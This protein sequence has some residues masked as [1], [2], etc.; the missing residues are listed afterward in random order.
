[1]KTNTIEKM[2]EMIAKAFKAFGHEGCLYRVQEA[3]KNGDYISAAKAI[4]NLKGSSDA[5]RQRIYA[6]CGGRSSPFAD[7]LVESGVRGIRG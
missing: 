1:M 2:N 4:D 6:F 3:M 7:A 5:C